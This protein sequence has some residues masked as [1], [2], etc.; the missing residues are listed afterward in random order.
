MK[1][2]LISAALAMASTSPA[3]AAA[4][5]LDFNSETLASTDDG[6]TGAVDIG[7]S[8]DFFGTAYSQLY[9]NNNGNVTFDSRLSAFTPFDLLSTSSVIIAPFF[10]D[11]DT[12]ARGSNSVTYGQGTVDGNSA[13]GVNWDGVGYYARADD[14]LNAFQLVIIERADLGAGNFDFEFNYDQIQWEAGRASGGRYGL[15]GSSA[16]AGFSNGST[17]QFELFG[18]AVNG[19]FLDTGP[20][21]TS[22]IANS[23]N[24]Q[25]DG[26]YVYQIRNGVVLDPNDTSAVPIPGAGLLM[27]SAALVFA[28]RRR[29]GAG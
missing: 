2:H 21:A 26:R 3:Y 7:F 12:R 8:F 22:L 1:R 17:D 16:R 9:V 10:G 24:S 6:S 23:H 15:G 18:S 11:V 20:I 13:F 25:V 4:I 19:A 27:A 5:R 29:G 14:L 28:S